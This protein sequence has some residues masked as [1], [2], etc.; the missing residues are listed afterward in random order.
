MHPTLTLMNLN[1]Q[2]TAVTVCENTGEADMKQDETAFKKS[3]N[4][5]QCAG[6]VCMPSLNLSGS[7]IPH[8][9]KSTHSY[10]SALIK[11]LILFQYHCSVQD[12]TQLQIN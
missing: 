1:T 9:E 11:T 5:I 12:V 8:R 4:G 10:T 7:T 6:K 2:P 3:L